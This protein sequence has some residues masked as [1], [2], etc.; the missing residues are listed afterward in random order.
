[1]YLVFGAIALLVGVVVV[2]GVAL[3]SSLGNI[4]IGR[5]RLEPIPIAASSCPY[6]R[7]VHD[8]AEPAGKT[9]LDALVSHR[10]DPRAWPIEAAQHAQQLAV[11]ELTLSAAIPHVP[12]R[13]AT[14]LERVKTNVAAGREALGAAGSESDY[15]SRSSG[16]VFDG[17]DALA[18]ASD[19]VGDACGFEVNPNV[20]GL[21]DGSG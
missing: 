2:A 3:V 7:Q 11:L 8:A 4:S 20:A 12:P 1:M 21:G 6:L 15:V 14:E 9:Y 13:V 16:Q 5:K 17:V 18:N 19:L 10:T